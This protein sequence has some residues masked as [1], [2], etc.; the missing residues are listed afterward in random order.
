M[1]DVSALE[2][3]VLGNRDMEEAGEIN[4]ME[5]DKENETQWGEFH[6]MFVKG[7]EIQRCWCANGLPECPEDRWIAFREFNEEESDLQS[8]QVKRAGQDGQWWCE[9]SKRVYERITDHSIEKNSLQTVFLTC[10][11][12]LSNPVIEED[13][14]PLNLEDCV[15]T[16]TPASLSNRSMEQL[17]DTVSSHCKQ[18][19]SWY[20]SEGTRLHRF[21]LSS[22]Y[23]NRKH[24]ELQPAGSLIHS[25][26]TKVL[27]NSPAP[28]GHLQPHKERTVVRKE[29]DLKLLKVASVSVH[30]S[31][32]GRSHHLQSLFQHWNQPNGKARLTVA[33]DFNRSLLV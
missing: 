20:K 22:L 8:E 30:V 31:G 7:E 3:S 19:K 4:I 2:V 1:E 26:K 16:H 29:P 15:K 23:I 12:S 11:P 33:Y 24:E 14:P 5:E 13:I 32:F 27:A 28:K 6:G 10:F 25:N 9:D 21:Y 18:Q 17:W